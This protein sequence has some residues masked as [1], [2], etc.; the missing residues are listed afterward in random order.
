MHEVQVE[1][2][3]NCFH[4]AQFGGRPSCGADLQQ[5]IVS[6]RLCEPYSNIDKGSYMITPGYEMK[7]QFC[8]YCSLGQGVE[9]ELN[10]P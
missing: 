3:L 9:N 6:S 7:V 1:A 8:R 2:C 10:S 5:H 4:V